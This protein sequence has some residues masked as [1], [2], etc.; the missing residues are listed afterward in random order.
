MPASDTHA[1][2][3]V[4]YLP[5]DMR[6][7]FDEPFDFNNSHSFGSM[8]DMT[9]AH[10]ESQTVSPS[11]LLIDTMSA[12]PSTTMTNLTTPGTSTY[13]SPLPLDSTQTSP[14]YED[15]TLDDST[16]WTPLFEPASGGPQ[17]RLRQSSVAP[18]MSRS[19]SSGQYEESPVLATVSPARMARVHSSPGH[20]AA[21]SGRQYSFSSGV[22]KREKPL[23]EIKVEDPNDTVALKRARNTMAARKSREKRVKEKETLM[24]EN[25][26]LQEEKE[27]LRQERDHWKNIA[28]RAGLSG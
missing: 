20:K 25:E 21:K 3:S 22:R 26:E 17:E 9:S 10:S 8:T 5:I 16:H 18:D 15:E 12:P 2:E 4:F 23:P 24:Q 13:D 28:I 11:E 6:S 7:E 27:A 19:S 14:L 1:M